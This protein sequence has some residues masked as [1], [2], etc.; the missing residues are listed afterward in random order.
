MTQIKLIIISI[1]LSGLGIVLL[2][3]NVGAVNYKMKIITDRIDKIDRKL[4]QCKKDT[5]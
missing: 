5:K 2:S 1:I 4:I 3:I